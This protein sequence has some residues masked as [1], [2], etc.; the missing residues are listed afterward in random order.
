LA[1]R[2]TDESFLLVPQMESSE[3]YFIRLFKG[4]GKTAG[5]Y[6]E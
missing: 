2:D 5:S 4:H 1:S 3:M 6:V